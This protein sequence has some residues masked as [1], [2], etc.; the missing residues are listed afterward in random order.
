M[1]VNVKGKNIEVTD[2]LKR[3]AEKKVEKL[4]KHFRT[5]REAQVTQSVQRNWHIVEVQLEGDGVVLR[6]EERTDNMYASI[7]QVVDKLEKRIMR[8]KGKLYG[9]KVDEGPREKEALKE[10]A[11]LEA[12][13]GPAEE[14]EL[15]EE[16]PTIVRTKRFA[17]K[18]MAP[19][20]AA[21]EMELLHHDFFMFLNDRTEQVN[22]V[23]KRRDG[24][25]GLIE[26]AV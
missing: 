18:P 26:P 9:K 15:E 25:Y 7:D 22:V 3:Y 14:A 24:N 13:G 2:A 5:I 19:D 1:L 10:A 4:G 16:M 17:V 6:G 11:T 20:E 23:Y 8:F 21:V 12:S